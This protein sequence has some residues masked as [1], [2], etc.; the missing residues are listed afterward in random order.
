MQTYELLVKNRAVRGNSPDM[1]LVRTSVGIDQIHVLFDNP[2]WLDFPITVTFASKNDMVTQSLIVTAV[3]SSEWVAEATMTIPWEVIDETGSIRVTFQGTDANGNHIITAKGS[4]LSVEEAGDV[5]EGSVPDDAP[6]VDQWQQAYADAMTAV[7]NAASLVANLQGQLESIVSDAI[8]E[9]Y[10]AV[11]IPIASEDT[12][13]VIKIGAGLSMSENGVLSVDSV[14]VDMSSSVTTA[15]SNLS[16]LARYAFDSTFNDGRFASAI[17]K[18]QVLPKASNSKFG[19]VAPDNDTTFVNDSGIISAYRY[20]LPVATNDTLGGVKLD[21]N[22]IISN[23]GVISVETATPTTFGLVKPDGVTITV[24]NG[25]ITASG[26]GS[27]GYILPKASSEQLGG[28][29]IGDGLKIDSN[30]ILSI[31]IE[32]ADEVGF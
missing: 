3:D 1:T 25:V 7:N 20:V 26:S 17:L 24:D 10:D 15:I 19:V 31:D 18:Q 13:G 9:V 28:V 27:D 12:A 2:E 4:P 21:G 5:E 16:L 6:S 32:V 23:D 14:P 22:T 11:N 29:L 30:G 8:G